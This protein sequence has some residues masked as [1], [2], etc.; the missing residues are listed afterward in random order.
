[1]GLSP[2][3]AAALPLFAL[4]LMAPAFA[5]RPDAP[6]AFDAI[7]IKPGDGRSLQVSSD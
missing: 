1:M 4:A 2:R 7:S 3:F 5:Q 6:A